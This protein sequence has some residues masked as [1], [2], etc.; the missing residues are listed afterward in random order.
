M[1]DVVLQLSPLIALP[2][3]GMFACFYWIYKEHYKDPNMPNRSLYM[4]LLQNQGT[5][6]SLCMDTASS[7]EKKD[8]ELSPLLQNKGTE[9]SLYIDTTASSW[10]KRDPELS[11][12]SPL[13]P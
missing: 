12:I 1:L 9:T 4:P 13:S 7:W 5:D 3:G 6:T 2:L 10:E 8:L 11:P